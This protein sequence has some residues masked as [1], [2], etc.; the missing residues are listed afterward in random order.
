MMIPYIVGLHGKIPEGIGN[1][2][3]ILDH[4]DHGTV[5]IG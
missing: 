4:T 3:Q 5:E 1:Q 2:Q